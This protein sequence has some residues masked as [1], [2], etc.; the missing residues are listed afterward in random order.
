MILFLGHLEELKS[1]LDLYGRIDKNLLDDPPTVSAYDLLHLMF[2]K[3]VNTMYKEQ[4][5]PLLSAGTDKFKPTSD[6]K[7]FEATL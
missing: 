1:K 5:G 3:V 6:G 4:W 7:T 2:S